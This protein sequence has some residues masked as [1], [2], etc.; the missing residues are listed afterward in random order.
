M[1]PPSKFYQIWR[2]EQL[3]KKQE[4]EERELEPWLKSQ[5]KV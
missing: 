4:T 2:E 5:K 1:S 3:K